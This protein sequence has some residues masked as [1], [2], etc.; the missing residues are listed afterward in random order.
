[1]LGATVARAMSEK[2]QGL[3]WD[4]IQE[5]RERIA[6][7]VN[8]TPVLTS[9]T[10]DA[11]ANARLYFKCENLQKVGAYKAR[12]ATNAVFALSEAEARKGVA[13]H[14]SGNHAAALARAARLRGIPA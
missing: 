5:A 12:G 10:L 6:G 9:S 4:Q 7:K 1:M 8:V 11:Q 13:T 2:P 14:S 3:T